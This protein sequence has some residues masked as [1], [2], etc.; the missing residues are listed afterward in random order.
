MGDT[1]RDPKLREGGELMLF[2]RVIAK[3]SVRVARVFGRRR[4]P[5]HPSFLRA[6][7]A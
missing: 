1:I 4:L 3:R 6:S 7:F 5:S 2:D